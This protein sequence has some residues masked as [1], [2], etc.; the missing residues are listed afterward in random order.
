MDEHLEKL[1]LKRI[2]AWVSLGLAL[3]YLSG[4]V[5]ASI[6]FRTHGIVGLVL[7]EPQYLEVGAAF[8]FITFILTIVPVALC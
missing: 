3:I 2:P 1:L 4:Y 6:Y 7:W 8:W 5:V